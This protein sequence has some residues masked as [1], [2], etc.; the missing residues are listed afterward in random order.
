MEINH[1]LEDRNPI[2]P[3][4]KNLEEYYKYECN[5]NSENREKEKKR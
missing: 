4:V 2:V 3:L 5:N 1:E